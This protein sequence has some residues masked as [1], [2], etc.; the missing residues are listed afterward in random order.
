MD[1]D[2]QNKYLRALADYQNLEKQ[3]QVWKED[4]LKFANQ[5]LIIQLLEVLDD[6]EKAQEHLNDEGL[7]IVLDKLIKILTNNG[8]EE[9]E[10]INKEY[11]AATAETVSVEPG[12]ENNVV[13]KVLQ[14]G[15]KLNGKIIRVAKVIVWQKL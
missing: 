6:L 12:E 1:D 11:D 15:Y 10:V 2:L 8:I 4:F 5:N 7:K 14:K 13:A 9:I 3:T